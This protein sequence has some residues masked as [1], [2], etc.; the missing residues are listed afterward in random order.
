MRAFPVGSLTRAVSAQPPLSSSSS[1]SHQQ[2]QSFASTIA[3]RFMFST[4]PLCLVHTGRIKTWMSGRGFGFVEDL[5][6]KQ[7]HFVHFSSLKIEAGGYRSVAVGQ[8][9]EFDVAQVD[10]RSRAENVTAPGGLPLPSGQRP[11]DQPAGHD[12]RQ[13]GTEKKKRKDAFSVDF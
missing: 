12:T 9:V 2:H 11:A 8:E 4:T 13:V 7:Q 5:E 3:R 1:F 10:G 6:T